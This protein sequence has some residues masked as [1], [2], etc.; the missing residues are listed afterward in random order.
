MAGSLA[1]TGIPAA[2]STLTYHPDNL[3]ATVGS[4]SVS[5]DNNGNIK[6]IGSCTT[7]E[8]FSYDPRGHLIQREWTP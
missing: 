6:C 8:L 5:S 2:I 7:G 4:T 1:K 3:L